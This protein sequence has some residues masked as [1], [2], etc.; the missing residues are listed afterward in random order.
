[1]DWETLLSSSIDFDWL[2]LYLLPDPD[3][4]LSSIVLLVTNTEKKKTYDNKETR[5][6]YVLG[7]GRGIFIHPFD[8]FLVLIK[9]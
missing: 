9:N 3:D 7:K 6:K 4:L 1:M 8:Y 5:S 2:F